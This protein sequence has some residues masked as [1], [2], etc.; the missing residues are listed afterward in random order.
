MSG[1]VSVMGTLPTQVRVLFTGI[2]RERASKNGGNPFNLR[3]PKAGVTGSNPVGCTTFSA[4]YCVFLVIAFER[5]CQ[6][7][8][9]Y[10]FM[11][12]QG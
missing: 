1:L 11:S 4:D 6:L 12:A 5:L 10:P 3:P 7:C 8:V 9:S 2:K